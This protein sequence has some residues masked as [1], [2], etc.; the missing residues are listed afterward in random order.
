MQSQLY[1][2]YMHA[3]CTVHDI[4]HAK[5]RNLPYSFTELLFPCEKTM[6]FQGM[7]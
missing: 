1:I 5:V 3:R 7:S 2:I 6:Q 4:L